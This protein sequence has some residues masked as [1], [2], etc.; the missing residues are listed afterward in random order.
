MNIKTLTALKGSIEKWEKITAG[1]GIDEGPL[2]CPACLM[3]LTH[4]CQGCP[5]YEKTKRRLC[6]NSPYDTWGWHQNI[7]HAEKKKERVYCPTCKK[8]AKAE[9]DF[10]KS[11]LPKPAKTTKKGRN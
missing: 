3:F 6:V 1:K 8:L 10:L 4:N 5:V 2:N 7:S 11:L 9:L